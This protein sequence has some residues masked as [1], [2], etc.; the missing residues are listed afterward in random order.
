M[1]NI[2]DASVRPTRILKHIELLRL[3]EQEQLID[4]FEER[5]D[6]IRVRH[7]GVNYDFTAEQALRYARAI[8]SHAPTFA[9]LRKHES[10]RP[11]RDSPP[12][13]RE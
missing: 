9:R 5:G 2:I 4:S 10:W 13:R 3:C 1:L 12:G 8:L 6:F 7:A 11:D